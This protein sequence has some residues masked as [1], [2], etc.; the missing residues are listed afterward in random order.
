[1]KIWSRM[2][3][4]YGH[5]WSS[6]YGNAL[7]EGELTDTAQLWRRSLSGLTPQ[8]IANGLSKCLERDDEWPPSLPAFRSLCTAM[9]D[10]SAENAGM[11]RTPKC[12]SL[13][14]PKKG[15]DHFRPFVQGLRSY[16]GGVKHEDGE[17]VEPF[18]SDPDRRREIE[19]EI[20]KAMRGGE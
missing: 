1:M 16:L 3:Q 14:K 13:P 11:Y 6:A 5:K 20:E 7:D 18:V 15:Y 2:A 17:K 12:L 4:M 8:Q 19:A 9:H 10:P